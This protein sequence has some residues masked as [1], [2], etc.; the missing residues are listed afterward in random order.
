MNYAIENG[1]K[2][3]MSFEKGTMQIIDIV[4]T[5]LRFESSGEY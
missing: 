5:G 4:E 2:Y 3:F 1:C